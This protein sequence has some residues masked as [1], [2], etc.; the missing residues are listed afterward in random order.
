VVAVI[1][2]VPAPCAVTTPLLFTVATEVLLLVHVT[3]LF[4]AL[5]GSMVGISVNV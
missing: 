4:V 3:V 1:I 2:T 5:A